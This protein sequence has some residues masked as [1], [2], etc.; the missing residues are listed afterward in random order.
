MDYKTH[1][2]KEIDPAGTHGQGSIETTFAKLLKAFG[3]PGSWEQYKTDAEW[4][5]Q[6]ED[7]SIATIYNWKDGK[8]YNGAEGE[9]IENIT[10]W[11]IGGKENSVVEK[12]K[13]ILS[14]VKEEELISAYWKPSPDENQ[15]LELIASMTID[16]VGRGGTDKRS[17]YISNIRAICN[18]MEEL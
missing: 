15:R 3:E 9:D 6:F 1:N 14:Q 5:V 12:L 18:Q 17:T 4:A 16:C 2:D 8:N 7:G 10:D 13:A 11:H